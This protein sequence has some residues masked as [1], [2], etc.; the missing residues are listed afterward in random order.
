MKRDGILR[1]Y[2][3]S[4]LSAL[5]ALAVVFTLLSPVPAAALEPETVDYTNR[6]GVALDPL[7]VEQVDLFIKG[8][9]QSGWWTNM[10][11][12]HFFCASNSTA[13]LINA[14]SSNM[15][16]TAV[17]GITHTPY[18]GF[19]GDGV[20]DYLESSKTPSNLVALG[21]ITNSHSMFVFSQTNSPSVAS[22]I[23]VFGP[24]TS[25]IGV[26]A[27]YTNRAAIW[28]GDN[29]SLSFSNS[30]TAKGLTGFVRDSS[31]G[32]FF[33]RNTENTD[34]RLDASST[35]PS[36][37]IRYFRL[38][39]QTYYSSNQLS[40]GFIGNGN[41]DRVQAKDLYI[42][43]VEMLGALGSWTEIDS[44]LQAY[45][46]RDDGATEWN[47]AF[48]VSANRFITR[49]KAVGW[50]SKMKAIHFLCAPSE[51]SA[52]RNVRAT[53]FNL[54]NFNSVAF[55]P[56]SGAQG[57]GTNSYLDIGA[58]LTQFGL[59]LTGHSFFVYCQSDAA[60]L[61][62]ELGAM[63]PVTNMIG[64]RTKNAGM[65]WL[66]SGSNNGVSYG[67]QSGVGLTGFVRTNSAGGFR[68]KNNLA[69]NFW[70]ATT[71]MPS[72]T[73]RY[74]RIG[75]ASTYSPNRLAFGFIGD[76]TVTPSDAADIYQN[77]YDMLE[78][79]GTRVEPD[80]AEPAEPPHAFR[81]ECITN[82]TP[83]NLR[84]F[85]L[86]GPPASNTFNF[87]GV[88][89]YS[90][91]SDKGYAFGPVTDV[92]SRPWALGMITSTDTQVGRWEMIWSDRANCGW[93]DKP[94]DTM[95]PIYNSS[96]IE[97]RTEF[98]TYSNAIGSTLAKTAYSAGLKFRSDTNH[99]DGKGWG[100]I[101][102]EW[103]YD[104][105]AWDTYWRGG[106]GAT[107]AIFTNDLPV[108]TG[109]IVHRAYASTNKDTFFTNVC[110]SWRTSYNRVILGPKRLCDLPQTM[111]RGFKL[112]HEHA[113]D[114]SPDLELRYIIEMRKIAKSKKYGL[115]VSGEAPCSEVGAH[116][117]WTITNAWQILTNMDWMVILAGKLGSTN[118]Q[119]DYL[120]EQFDFF[121]GPQTN[122]TVPV[123]RLCLQLGV[124]PAGQ[125]IP[126]D[127]TLV[128]RNFMISKGI[129]NC[130][131][132][133]G[134]ATF[135]GSITRQPNQVIA[136]F[137]GLST[138]SP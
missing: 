61:W 28:S 106:A 107:N 78:L 102:E 24:V 69:T 68:V 63:G 1:L 79:M 55:Y 41:I 129:T 4:C 84:I 138:N 10:I 99:P 58:T 9:K 90:N 121:K 45:I 87:V 120:Q 2:A 6:C 65:A 109:A 103:G 22:D 66:F 56:N 50:W 27:N 124:G 136:T 72:S 115:V 18:Q 126:L 48:L 94:N 85:R 44:D 36:G 54:T 82:V 8:G 122:K 51:Q 75:T 16:L 134:Y 11:A 105:S 23:G 125:E 108:D 97:C 116:T 88:S 5:F 62:G 83:A 128:A 52:K 71:V 70:L 101:A 38:G 13:A 127:Q 31:T 37:T 26:R 39:A 17:G 114:R 123:S 43:C 49:A 130:Y 73:F 137:L 132:V 104:V 89:P 77:C 35:L 133:P 12:I 98:T 67:V 14:K 29:T 95:G 92:M 93:G 112:D 74:F 76:S 64:I 81:R 30:S 15:T 3:G 20:D 135:G 57:N 86:A 119:A 46:D 91:A 47:G 60:G 113:D 32:G 34:F 25:I 53:N 110:L 111:V 131:I 100:D 80:L 19:K 40:F 33:V 59:S 21:F 96:G 42:R 117:G 118:E 7:F